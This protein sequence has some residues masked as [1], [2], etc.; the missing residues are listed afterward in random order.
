MES[1]D[2]YYNRGFNKSELGDKE[3]A[4]AEDGAQASP[5]TIQ[6]SA[7]ILNL[8]KLITI[9]VLINLN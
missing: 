3:G 7:L 1:A 6:P 4:T 8:P 5:T 9:G 2:T